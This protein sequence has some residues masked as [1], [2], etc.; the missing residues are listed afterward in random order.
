M[1][2]IRALTDA[3]VSVWLDDLGRHRIVSGELGELVNQTGIRGVTTNP[4][5]FAAEGTEFLD[6]YSATRGFRSGTPASIA[7]PRDA[8]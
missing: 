5:I 2:D 6:R 4:S 8:R 7:I 3:G 1:T